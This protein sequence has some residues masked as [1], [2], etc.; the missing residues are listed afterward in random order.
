MTHAY[1]F[2]AVR[3][4]RGRGKKDG[5]LHEV[6][7]VRLLSG[8]LAALRD[9]NGLDTSQVDDVVTG[10]VM[11]VGDQ[12]AD[13]GR[14]AV[15]AAGWSDGVPAVT[16]NR[17]C[18]SGLESVNLAAMKVMSGQEDLVV[19]SGVESMSRVAMGADGGAGVMDPQINYLT[20][21]IPQ[22][23]CADVLATMDGYSREDVDAVAVRSH[24]RAAQAQAEG[25][26]D[27]SIVPVRD[28]NG[29]LILDR[30]ETV[31][32]ATTL[33]TLGALKPSFQQQG[34]LVFDGVALAQYPT[35]ERINHVHHAGNS[36][37]VVDGA[38]AV[39]IGSAEKGRA[40]GLKARGRIR[41]CA[42][43]GTEPAIMLTGPA[44]ASLKALK[45]AGMR[46]RDID[47][48]EINEAFASVV[49]RLV[50]DLDF[51]LERVNV[52]GGSIAMGHPLGA[53]GSMMIGIALD[54]LERQDKQT[55][56]LT[57]CVAGG[58]GIATVIERV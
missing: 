22:G 27:K 11:A 16:Q 48:V 14:M 28:S 41:A 19:A 33:E 29:L 8:V 21:Y 23:V 56:L 3:T 40:L 10:C 20:N 46:P 50:R 31:R 15:L 32:P 47:L 36:S 5:S 58:M 17:F 2:D 45:K 39:L 13:I 6:P 24:Q 9:R 37:G 49:L 7:P 57:L 4:P 51:D 42:V 35:L 54:E 52:N 12:G 44:P 30:D 53:T 43:V 18:A 25:R 55:A 34:E 1:I 38:A 26:F